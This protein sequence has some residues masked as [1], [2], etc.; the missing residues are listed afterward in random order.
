LTHVV[1]EHPGLLEADGD[2]TD[3]VCITCSDEGRV[4]EVRSLRAGG[5][6]EVIVNG[7]PETID[8]SLVEPVGPGDL[9]LVH[10]GV[11]LTTLGEIRS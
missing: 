1:F 4:A 6:V 9:L 11:A 7:H 3:D 5:M 2:W 8:A 10:A